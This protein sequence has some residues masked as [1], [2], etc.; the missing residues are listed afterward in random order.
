MRAVNG[1]TTIGATRTKVLDEN[2]RRSFATFTN[3][4]DEDI[5]LLF[6]DSGADGS[7]QILKP[8]GGTYEINSTNE[9]TGYVYAICASGSKNLAWSEITRS[10]NA[11]E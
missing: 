6:G 11:R 3:N 7:G 5:S 1:V 4:S 2:F 9:W 8:A 10:E